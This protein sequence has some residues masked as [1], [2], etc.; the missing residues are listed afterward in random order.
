MTSSQ[1]DLHLPAPSA[2]AE[3]PLTPAR[4]VN[5]YVYCPRLAYLMWGQA[6]WA[7]TADTVD[8]KRVHARV[9][10][11]DKPLPDPEEPDADDAAVATRSLTLSS[12]RIGVI[13]KIDV[14]EAR[15]GVVTPID[16][17]RGKRPHVARG[18]YEPERVQALSDRFRGLCAPASLKLSVRPLKF[19]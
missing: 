11:A 3:T 14:A 16:Y 1:L 9:D 7:D 13:A 12:E 17:K 19:A 8:G 10:R 2:T 15:D 18:A 6:E 4:M 5:E